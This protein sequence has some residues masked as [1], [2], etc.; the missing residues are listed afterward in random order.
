MTAREMLEELM[1]TRCRCGGPK[2]P[3][4][5]F[6]TR[7]FFALPAAMRKNLYQRIGEGYETAY[8]AAV[9]RLGL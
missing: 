5:T 6:C 8:N 4:K 7:C 3:K 1:G 9:V 2:P